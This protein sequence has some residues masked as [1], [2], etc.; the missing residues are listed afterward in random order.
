MESFYPYTHSDTTITTLDQAIGDLTNPLSGY[1]S[2]YSE[3]KVIGVKKDKVDLLNELLGY[4]PNGFSK[5]NKQLIVDAINLNN[6]AIKYPPASINSSSPIIPLYPNLTL[7]IPFNRVNTEV[8]S[9]LGSNLETGKRSYLAFMTENIQNLVTDPNYVKSRKYNL[10]GNS[11]VTDIYPQIEVWMWV[12]SIGQLINIS[13]FID[14]LSISVNKN[15]GNFQ[16]SLAPI[17]ELNEGSWWGDKYVAESS[18]LYKDGARNRFAFHR[19]IQSNDLVFIKFEELAL[20]DEDREIRSFYVSESNL[21]DQI[22]DMIGL[23]DN[24]ILSVIPSSNDVRINITGRD[25][26][27]LFTEDGSQFI[28]IA[29]LENSSTFFTSM[30]RDRDKFIQRNFSGTE[31]HQVLC[32]ATFVKIDFAMKFI[33]NQCSTIGIIPNDLLRHYDD[34]RTEHYE[35]IISKDGE[36]KLADKATPVDGLWQIVKLHVDKQLDHRILADSSLSQPDGTIMSQFKK[37]CQEPFVELITDTYG[38]SYH[39]IVRQSPFTADAIIGYIKENVTTKD[40]IVETVKEKSSLTSGRNPTSTHTVFDVVPLIIDVLDEDIIDETLGFTEDDI[41]TF[42]DLDINFLNTGDLLK[43]FVPICYFPKYVDIW[44][45]RKFSLTDIYIEQ[46]MILGSKN[47][48]TK[49]V[50]LT[51]IATSLVNDMMLCIECYAYVPFTRKGS[52]TL[53]GDRRIKM[54]TWIRHKGTNE[55]Y[56]VDSVSN[57]FSIS[58]SSIDRTTTLQVSRGMVEDYCI[59]PSDKTDTLTRSYFN[60]INVAQIRA[61]IND[62]INGVIKNG[63]NN[64]KATFSVNEDVFDFF[65]QRK[66]FD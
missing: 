59:K 24:N 43:P 19:I 6:D 35:G 42:Y 1:L 30:S 57:S 53:N 55:I 32:A 61:N 40:K 8:V 66:Q 34:K 14:H 16:L 29:Y 52:I 20:R 64:V 25:C 60:I 44:G 4:I 7:Y 63:K 41:F 49:D 26:S 31:Y 18:S 21:P 17:N 51:K 10:T 47:T 22:Y 58:D 48:L 9:V 11:V 15:G 56:Y 39:V 28:P 13:P 3:D 36:K 65:V 62:V 5:T 50:N 46:D 45:N 12:R 23:V 38:D 2:I 54:G 27:K 33:M 37:I